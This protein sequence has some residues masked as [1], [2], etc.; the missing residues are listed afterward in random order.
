MEV[1]VGAIKITDGLFIGDEFAAQDLEFIVA[2]KVTHVVNCSARQ[3]PNHWEPIGVKYLSFAWLDHDSQ[4]ILDSGDKNFLAICKFLKLAL[5]NG[6]SVLVHSVRGVSR[7]VCVVAAYLMKRFSWGLYKALEFIGS[8]R[9][10][11]D[12]KPGFVNQLSNFE[13][14]LSKTRTLTS[15][16]QRHSEDSE[17]QVLSNTFLNSRINETAD[18]EGTYNGVHNQRL[19][20]LEGDSNEHH[21][22]SKNKVEDGYVVLKS[23]VKGGT[24]Q[25]IVPLDKSK[26][27]RIKYGGLL[28]RQQENSRQRIP[29]KQETPRSSRPLSASK[30]E[31]AKPNRPQES[32]RNPLEIQTIRIQKKEQT[33]TSKRPSTAPNKRASA[34]APVR[35]KKSKPTSIPTLKKFK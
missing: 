30:K 6:E 9:P 19:Q 12:L 16:W 2:N 3:V 28:G 8:R 14:R 33:K 31:P 4:I 21:L 18:Y 24:E 26:S 34:R 11:I 32:S 22:K 7:S 15:T 1:L 29:T 20:W 25:A 35:T 5:R 17:E 10:D 27:S 13:G 23:C